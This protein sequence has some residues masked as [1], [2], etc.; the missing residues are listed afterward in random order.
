MSRPFAAKQTTT[1]RRRSSIVERIINIIL[2]P[3]RLLYK[4]MIHRNFKGISLDLLASFPKVKG[5]TN[6][7]SEIRGAIVYS[8]PQLFKEPLSLDKHETMICFSESQRK[9]LV[10]NAHLC[11]IMRYL[12]GTFDARFHE[13]SVR[14]DLCSIIDF[15]FEYLGK[16]K[17]VAITSLIN[18]GCVLCVSLGYLTKLINE[19]QTNTF[20]F[21]Y[22]EEMVCSNN[23]LFEMKSDSTMMI[24]DC[25][26]PGRSR[27]LTI[28]RHPSPYSSNFVYGEWIVTDPCNAPIERFVLE[29]NCRYPK[30]KM[31]DFNLYDMISNRRSVLPYTILVDSTI[32]MYTRMNGDYVHGS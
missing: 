6:N 1:L 3:N 29:S 4:M 10:D 21:T 7:L 18:S 8:F 14:S 12:T 28:H 13:N 2:K 25:D 22:S 24:T 9:Q 27:L 5:K 11:Q 31:H 19:T 26:F 17:G 15:Q 32:L 20:C 23:N 16:T 30:I